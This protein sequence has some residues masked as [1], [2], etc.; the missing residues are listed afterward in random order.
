M[1][2]ITKLL[3]T[4]WRIPKTKINY[5]NCATYLENLSCRSRFAKI[6]ANCVRPGALHPEVGVLHPLPNLTCCRHVQVIVL[7][8]CISGV[9]IPCWCRASALQTVRMCT[10]QFIW[11]LPNKA[12]CHTEFSGVN[13]TCEYVRPGVPGSE[14]LFKTGSSFRVHYNMVTREEAA[15]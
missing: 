9:C 11:P 1:Q 10:S 5:H 8:S 15:C 14:V 12:P 6:A 7:S 4:M 13:G 2:F 3:M